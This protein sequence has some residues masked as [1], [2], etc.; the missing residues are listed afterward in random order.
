[1]V[2]RRFG[3]N[4]AWFGIHIFGGEGDEDVRDMARDGEG[5]LVVVGSSDS[6]TE[7]TGGN[8]SRDAVLFRA[9]SINLTP[10]FSYGE[11]QVVVEGTSVFVGMEEFPATDRMQAMSIQAGTPLPVE[12]GGAWVLYDIGGKRV[13]QGEGPAPMPDLPGWTRLETVTDGHPGGRWIW[14]R[15]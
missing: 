7:L 15:R 4:G 1:M 10:S 6:W 9:S 2:Q 12:P 13:A 3:P 5:R 11:A 8:G 14:V